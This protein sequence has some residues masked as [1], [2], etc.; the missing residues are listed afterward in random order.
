VRQCRK[1]LPN[2]QPP[3]QPAPHHGREHRCVR[4]RPPGHAAPFARHR[5]PYARS[6]H[7]ETTLQVRTMVDPD[8]QTGPRQMTVGMG[9]PSLHDVAKLHVRG[10]LIGGQQPLVLALDQ[11]LLAK[12]IWLNHSRR[13][14]HMRMRVANVSLDMRLVDGEVDS[15]A[16]PIGKSWAKSRTRSRRCAE[17]SSCGSAISNSRVTLASLRFSARSAAFHSIE[18]SRAQSAST[19]SGKTISECS[20]PCLRV[21][22]CTTHRARSGSWPQCDGQRRPRRLVRRCGR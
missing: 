20:M 11:R 7:L 16:V 3:C 8:I 10:R 14:Q 6:A 1:I 4:A 2:P 21:K 18:R 13:Q 19:P 12:T 5:R 9:F 15:S 22:S 17:L